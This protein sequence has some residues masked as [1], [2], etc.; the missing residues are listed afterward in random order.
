MDESFRILD[1]CVNII[2]SLWTTW[3]EQNMNMVSV[4]K[5]DPQLL[6]LLWALL[7]K[8][9]GSKQLLQKNIDV[10]QMQRVLC[11]INKY[12]FP[13][14][15]LSERNFSCIFTFENHLNRSYKK[16]PF[17]VNLQKRSSW[18]SVMRVTLNMQRWR[19]PTDDI[20]SCERIRICEN[21]I[22]LMNSRFLPSWRNASKGTV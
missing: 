11:Y 19:D 22:H 13:T 1:H 8:A 6:C 21:I 17:L 16:M 20:M 3:P 18:S 15:N 10:T 2:L 4:R 14:K 12:S 5:L 7:W 9:P